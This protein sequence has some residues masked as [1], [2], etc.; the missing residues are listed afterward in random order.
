MK[1]DSQSLC[2]HG[3]CTGSFKV[4]THIGHSY[5]LL[6]G[7]KNSLVKPPVSS[8]L[9][10][11]F[12]GIICMCISVSKFCLIQMRIKF[13]KVTNIPLYS[14]STRNLG[15][16]KSLNL[17]KSVTIIRVYFISYWHLMIRH[18]PYKRFKKN[19]RFS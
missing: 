9:V 2:P 7:S 14:R 19:T 15:Y 13:R 8:S 4:W 3:N 1:H 6:T 16:D 10:I 18:C 17:I 5:R 11:S 12:I